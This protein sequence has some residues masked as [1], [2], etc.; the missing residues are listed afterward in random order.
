MSHSEVVSG[1]ASVASDLRARVSARPRRGPKPLPKSRFGGNVAGS[2][3]KHTP[4]LRER[5]FEAAQIPNSFLTSFRN[6]QSV[7][8]SMILSGD[9]LIMPSSRSISAQKRTASSAS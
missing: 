4:L 5:G 8:V 7:P 3:C 2:A 6:R 9:D 1:G